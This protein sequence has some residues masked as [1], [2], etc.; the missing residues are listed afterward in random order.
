MKS[1][2][3]KLGLSDKISCCLE[4]SSTEVFDTV[5]CLD[6]MEH[7]PNPSQQLLNFHKM[8]TSS[9]KIILNWYFFKG[10]NQEFPFHLE[11]EE[12]V[13]TFFLL[14]SSFFLLPSCICLMLR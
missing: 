14:P 10:F 5:I 13:N 11:D 7:L 6:A 9:G 4:V 8:L 1:R 12:E 2:A 3:A